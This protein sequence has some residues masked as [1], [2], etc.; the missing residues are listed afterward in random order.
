MNQFKSFSA[1]PEWFSL[2]PPINNLKFFFDFGLTGKLIS[3]RLTSKYIIINYLTK[4]D[5]SP[6]P[7][8]GTSTFFGKISDCNFTENLRILQI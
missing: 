5:K 4:F 3:T 1:Y 7:N 6:N 8:K 2:D